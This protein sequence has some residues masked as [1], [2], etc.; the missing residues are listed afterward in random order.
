MES[1]F[2]SEEFQKSA[3]AFKPSAKHI[4]LV[5]PEL[6]WDL[7]RS[8]YNIH[9][10]P[11]LSM[12]LLISFLVFVFSFV[13]L[14]MPL[15]ATKSQA[16]TYL[17][18]SIPFALSISAFV[19]LLLLPKLKLMRRGR[20]VERDLEFM[21]KDMQVQLTAGVPLFNCLANIANGGYGECSAIITEIVGEIQSGASMADVLNEYGMSSPSEHFRRALWQIS[22]AMR[23]G[24]DIK[25][26]IGAI[27]NDIRE[28]KENQIKSYGKELSLWGLIYMMLTIVA[29]SMGVTLLL[30][31]SSFLGSASINEL[32]F[33][34]VLVGIIVFQLLF[35]TIIKSKR[36]FV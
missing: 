34:G 33:W 4:A 10:V 8:E 1:P 22:N 12:A 18:G 31:L 35:I 20:A 28:E 3:S 25:T 9:A 6:E 23:V 21:L 13:L 17:V 36:P 30:I 2:N 14:T 29:P 19:Y 5:F 26:A 16:D 27:S 32:T 11:Y 15:L 24:S 7:R